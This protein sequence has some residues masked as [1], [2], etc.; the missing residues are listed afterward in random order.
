M[1]LSHGTTA[2]LLPSEGLSF[3][4]WKQKQSPSS[5]SIL[6]KVVVRI[7]DTEAQCQE[8]FPAL[9]RASVS[10]NCSSHEQKTG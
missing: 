10:W 6:D 3:L 1:R 7:R 2:P 9:C 5:S 8:Q 4:I